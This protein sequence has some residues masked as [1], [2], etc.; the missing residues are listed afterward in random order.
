[1]KSY[2]LKAL[3]VS[4]LFINS[5]GYSNNSPKKQTVKVALLLDTSNSMDGLINQ[6][7]AQLWEIVNELSYAKYNGVTPNLEIALYEYGNDRLSAKN[8]YIRKVLHFTND[9]D[10]ISERLFS[11]TTNGGSE[12]CGEVIQTSLNELEWGK[13]RND[14]KMIFIAGNEPF[15]QGNTYYKDAITNAKEKG[16]V[17]NTI[18]CGDY[19]NGISGSWKDGA[20]LGNGDYMTIN[21][22]KNIVHIVT[23]YDKDILILNKKLNGTY[24]YYGNKGFSKYN[25]QSLQDDNAAALNEEVV[26]KRAV[27]KS[28]KLYSNA[29]WDLVDASSNKKMDYRKLKKS[30]LPK[31]LQNKS[32]KELK[33]YVEKKRTE[34]AR[35]QKKIQELNK[36]RKIYVA[37]KRSKNDKK[38]ELESVMIKAIKKQAKKKNYTW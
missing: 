5:F 34:R 20:V 2:V 1:M 19:Q 7:K 3:I 10:D 6:A 13:E 24:I 17:V 15:T 31:H 32:E 16:I 29:E 4:F 26:V 12:Y 21:H 37:T 25:K 35:I 27:T 8:G 33:A 11:L 36:K 38:N 23:P 18:F 22:N 30:K 28:S 9:L 14:L